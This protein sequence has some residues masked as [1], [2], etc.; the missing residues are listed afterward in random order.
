GHD[1]FRQALWQLLWTIHG[2]GSSQKSSRSLPD[3]KKLSVELINRKARVAM[4][5][6]LSQV[7]FLQD[8]NNR[9]QFMSADDFHLQ[10]ARSETFV[11]QI[12]ISFVNEFGV[13]EAGIDGGGIFKDFMENIIQAAFDV[14]YGLFKLSPA[15]WFC[16]LLAGICITREQNEATSLSGLS[17]HTMALF[18]CSEDFL[19]NLFPGL[20][21]RFYI[22]SVTGTR[23]AHYWVVLP[24]STVGGG[25]R[26]KSIVDGRLREKKNEE[27]EE[28]K[29]RKS[30][31]RKKYLLSPC[32]P[33]PRAIAA[34]TCRRFFSRAM[35]EG[36][37]VDIPFA[38]FFLS[39]L[40]E[41]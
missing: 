28:K 25:L 3:D 34:L 36:I 10:E 31:R 27:E 26:E 4:S 9:R 23:T 39:K 32:R 15:A 40:K 16:S 6:L 38:T 41:K 12:R 5:E 7:L 24:K 14:Q 13:E 17:V 18:V 11:S 19:R 30:R 33:R 2:H 29:K 35:Y 8:W 37:L 21:P 1:L 20:E 22:S